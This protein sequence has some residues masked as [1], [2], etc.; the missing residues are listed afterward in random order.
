MKDSNNLEKLTQDYLIKLVTYNE[1]TGIFTWKPRLI[2]M[3]KPGKSQCRICK[4]WNTRFANKIAGNIW[5]QEESKTSYI[6]IRITLNG[7]SKLYYAHRLAILYT[8]GHLPLEQVDH[9]DG[10]GL[11]NRRDNLR[12]V[13]NQENNK[14]MPMRSDNTSGYTGVYWSKRDQ[15]WHARIKVNGKYIHGGYF[16][17][18]E[19]AITKR[20][21]ME[22]EYEFHSNHGRED[23]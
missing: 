12:E 2:N 11:N 6:T 20:K 13:S 21:Q 22:V 14:N 8:E 1:E 23:Q 3:F 5:T 7:K 4:T 16:T 9:I 18:K 19:K 10:N 17:N 15:K